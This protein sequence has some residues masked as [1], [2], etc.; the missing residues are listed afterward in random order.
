M[1]LMLFFCLEICVFL[2]HGL[3]LRTFV[4][5]VHYL[6]AASDSLISLLHMAEITGLLV[7][8]IKE[9]EN[10]KQETE[11]KAQK[12]EILCFKLMHIHLKRQMSNRSPIHSIHV[13]NLTFELV[14]LHLC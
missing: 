10:F 4:H 7:H 3:S 1:A 8:S 2:S 13:H 6:F 5:F 9:K 14:R 12:Y 11:A